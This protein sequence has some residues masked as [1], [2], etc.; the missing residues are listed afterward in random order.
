MKAAREG[1][2][3]SEQ[4][5]EERDEQVQSP[6]DT[7]FFLLLKP[8]TPLDTRNPATYLWRWQEADKSIFC[9]SLFSAT[10]IPLLKETLLLQKT[11]VIK[12]GEG[13]GTQ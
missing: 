1:M 4:S 9:P 12:K 8:P 7:D 13:G 2:E 10:A 11:L 5:P 3:V 6:W